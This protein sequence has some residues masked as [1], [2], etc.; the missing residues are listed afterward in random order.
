MVHYNNQLS[1][2]ALCTS[3]S[4]KAVRKKRAAFLFKKNPGV[5]ANLHIK[6][7]PCFVLFLV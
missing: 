1:C 2:F 5:H 3:A 4:A 6:N 7:T